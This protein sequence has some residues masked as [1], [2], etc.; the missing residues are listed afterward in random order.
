MGILARYEPSNTRELWRNAAVFTIFQAAGWTDFFECL[1]GFHCES[2][3]QFALNLTETHS[4]VWGLHIEV[5]EAIMAEVTSLPQV[6]RTWFRHQTPAT[7]AVQDFLMEG[8]QVQMR[9]R[10]I[11]LQS[12]PQPWNQVAIFL[13]K[14]ITHEGRYQTVYN[15]ELPLLSHLCH[16]ILLNIPYYLLNDLH[17]MA[18]FVQAAKHPL[19]SLTHHGLIKLI[20]LRNLSQHNITLEQF[21]AQAQEPAPFPGVPIEEEQNQEEPVYPQLGGNA[22]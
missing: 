2:A 12:L 19:T 22:E 16:R 20:I 3:L 11:V 13:K 18:W 8:E 1:N 6:G 10:G 4:K 7:A 21:T 9:Q 15:S 17:H 14:Y 5:S